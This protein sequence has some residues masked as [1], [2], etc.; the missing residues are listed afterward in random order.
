MRNLARLT[1]NKIKNAKPGPDGKTNLLCD[2][3]GLWLQVSAGKDGQI[4]KSWLFRYAAAGNK[5]SRTGR[6][7]RRERQMGLG[8]V[9]T[10]RL[11]DA[12]E[13][14]RQA[15]MLVLQGRDPLDEKDASRAAARAAQAK[16]QTFAEAA[17]AYLA[18]FEGGWKNTKHRE[19]WRRSLKTY[20]LPVLGSLD[21]N[22]IDTVDVLRVLEPIWNAKA[23]TAS[24]IRGRIET[25]LDYAGRNEANPARWKGHLEHKLAKRNKARTV[26][27][28][29]ALPYTEIGAFMAEL[30]TVESIP[31]RALELTILCAT[32]TSETLSA[33]W[34]EFDLD[35]RIWTIPASRTK[36]DREHAVPLSDA[37]VAV[38]R[39]MAS[40]RQ[41]DRV[42]HY[43]ADAMRQCL[44]ASRP[45]TT[46][47]GFR[48][49]FRSWAGACTT[50][51]RDVCEQALGHAIGNA[52]EDMRDSL[53]AKRRV[54]MADW[55]EFCGREP[56]DLV[57]MDDRRRAPR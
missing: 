38:L 48:S 6:E 36:R 47:H 32:R 42:F 14:A 53:L 30:R 54:L 22:S 10:V 49:S 24:R 34:A 7:Y 11:A 25:V 43:S 41:D 16:R 2:G 51:S 57:R 17:D 37:A 9:H 4:N 35:G 5:I 28:L 31:A 1:S 52:V 19:Q 50:H 23:E 18:R 56:A 39:A 12:R 27:H 26:R 55:S 29:A 33:R 8:P 20:I 21:V 3:G 40:V 45:G 44:Q 15:R 46:V 13:M